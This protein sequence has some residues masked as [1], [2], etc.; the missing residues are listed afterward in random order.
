MSLL[1]T[2]LSNSLQLPASLIAEVEPFFSEERISRNDYF[3]RYNNRCNR[4]SVIAAGYLRFYSF[5]EGKE[6]T[7]W[8]FGENHLITDV[9]GFFLGQELATSD[10]ELVDL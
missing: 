6:I 9:G 3:C 5:S 1:A 10:V 8:I 2:F 4:M 7:H